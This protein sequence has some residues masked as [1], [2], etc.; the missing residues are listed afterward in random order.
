M[1]QNEQ[2]DAGAAVR[3]RRIPVGIKASIALCALCLIWSAFWFVAKES[4][5]NAIDVW[6]ANERALGRNWNCASHSM[7]GFPL[8]L[9]FHCNAPSFSGRLN[10]RDIK[11]AAGD[12][13]AFANLWEP[14]V[15]V[16]DVA[17]P[18]HVTSQ[19]GN[20]DALVEW[21]GAR[22]VIG[23]AGGPD[24][25]GALAMSDARLR[26]AFA[27]K[28]GPQLSIRRID[29]SVV[30]N[31][32]PE[33]AR[34][35][36]DIDVAASGV[37]SPGING[38]TG[39]TAAANLGIVAKISNVGHAAGNLRDALEFWRRAGGE[40]NLTKGAFSKGALVLGAQG[41]LGLDDAHRLA[42]SLDVEA[43]GLAPLLPRLGLPPSAIAVGNLLDR[44]MPGRSGKGESDA[45]KA[46][47]LPV[48]FRNGRIA[49][50]VFPTPLM[51]LPLY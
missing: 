45:S 21:S 12:L 31:G 39:E 25:R 47:R 3:R 8:R 23:N 42:G 4:T 48:A 11:G 26:F 24:A 37:D 30:A 35:D 22:V 46:L 43:T 7:S 28:E 32:V 19:D 41:K 50:G 40:I 13:V 34:V 2:H 18:V 6:F 15:I 10:G 20:L 27:N 9:V 38:F 14:H 44:F 36:A 29:A 16:A 5:A 17:S 1:T 33:I 49:V 51:L